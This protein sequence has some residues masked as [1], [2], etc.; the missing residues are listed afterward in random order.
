ME[1]WRRPLQRMGY[2]FNV[3]GR[4]LKPNDIFA[5]VAGGKLTIIITTL[6]HLNGSLYNQ[7]KSAERLIIRAVT[8]WN[9][10]I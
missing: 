10:W 9:H 1:C 7:S 5:T 4:L 8:A 3:D 2:D 6:H